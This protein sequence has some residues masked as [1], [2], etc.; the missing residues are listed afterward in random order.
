MEEEKIF[1]EIN[2]HL[3]EDE[4]PS[5][6]IRS[7]I[8]KGLLRE[9]PFNFISKLEDI[10][11]NKKYHPEGNVLEHTLMVVD[12]AAKI[13]NLSKDSKAFMWAALFHDLGKITTTKLRD[14]RIT[15]YNHDIEGEKIV[16]DI[17]EKL[18]VDEDFKN[19][20]L[21]LV[22]YHMHTFFINKNLPFSD[23]K[24]LL[25]RGDVEEVALISLADRLGRGEI[26][27]FGKKEVYK[28]IEDFREKVK[29]LK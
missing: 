9:E 4:K 1:K 25:S 13:K 24:G 10:P 11:Q 12:E 15:S 21:Y 26:D 6:Y 17:L 28:F 5:K 18:K 22:R 23:I 16:E 20:V 8:N 29:T 14:G 2:D 27:D 19:K 7:M 3:L